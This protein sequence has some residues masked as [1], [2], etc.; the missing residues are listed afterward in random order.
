MTVLEA[1][2]GKVSPSTKVSSVKGCNV[3]DSTLNEIP[4]ARA[5]ASK[6]DIA[7]VVV[8]E[9]ERTDGESDDAADLD[10][11]GYQ[12]ELI[13]AV[14]ETGTPIIVV[15]ISG[16]PL[17]IRWTA[18]HVPAIIEAWMCGER[19]GGAIAEVLFG[20]V[21]PNGKLPI[22]FPQHVGQMPFYYNYKPAKFN[23][24]WR[25]YVTYPLTPF[26]GIW[27]RPELYRIRVFQP[28]YQSRCY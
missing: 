14:Q 3:L 13:K 16:R 22:T 23:R 1:I 10:L 5:A 28:E 6:A 7:V 2:Q 8:G 18:E 12:A 27:L 4:A 17:T 11:T 21:N 26:T 25:A 9:D 15:L 19:G 20:E 24:H